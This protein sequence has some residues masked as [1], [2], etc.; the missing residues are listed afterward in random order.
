MSA[1]QEATCMGPRGQNTMNASIALEY[2]RYNACM[3]S[4]QLNRLSVCLS[5]HLSNGQ[6]AGRPICPSSICPSICLRVAHNPGGGTASNSRWRRQ[7][8]V[9]CQ[10]IFW[11]V[12]GSALAFI[13]DGVGQRH[14][15]KAW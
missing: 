12:P 5:V 15:G 14:H 8:H 7:R 1:G 11:E 6:P 13:P 4:H 10:P 3:P 9:L 2:H